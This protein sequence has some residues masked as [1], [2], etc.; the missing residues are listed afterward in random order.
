MELNKERLETIL[1]NTIDLLRDYI[2]EENL[3]WDWYSSEVG[4]K[5][6]ESTEIKIAFSEMVNPY[7]EY[8]YFEAKEFTYSDYGQYVEY[9][10]IKDGEKY[11]GYDKLDYF[12][13]HAAVY[14]PT[15]NWQSTFMQKLFREI[16]ESENGMLFLDAI[17]EDSFETS[18]EP[19]KFSEEEMGK[20]FYDLHNLNYGLNKIRNVLEVN[21]GLGDWVYWCKGLEKKDSRYFRDAP[22]DGAIV[23]YGDFL[24]YF[25]EKVVD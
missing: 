8:E 21:M 6:N 10:F 23:A 7:R 12:D 9:T 11:H 25:N 22:Q 2:P 19:Q 13:P 24:C 20:F 1:L 17:D 5:E 4:L 16:Q 14:T 3:N 18:F 15:I